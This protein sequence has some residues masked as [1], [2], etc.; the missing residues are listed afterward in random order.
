MAGLYSPKRSEQEWSDLA[1]LGPKAERI[2]D[3]SVVAST[4]KIIDDWANRR[5][6]RITNLGSLVDIENLTQRQITV[7][8]HWFL[9]VTR[10]AR[11]V[12]EPYKGQ[13]WEKC[14]PPDTLFDLP[15]HPPGEFVMHDEQD[16]EVI[17]LREVRTCSSCRGKGEVRCSKC[18]GKGTYRCPSCGG[19]GKKQRTEY[20]NG[21][22]RKYYEQCSRCRGSKKLDCTTCGKSGWVQC[23]TCEGYGKNLF[24]AIVSTSYKP[25]FVTDVLY[26]GEF[27]ANT[28]AD[29][30]I[31]GRKIISSKV[32]NLEYSLKGEVGP[33]EGD[34]NSNEEALKYVPYLKSI[35]QGFAHEV[36][37]DTKPYN[38]HVELRQIPV[39]EVPYQYGKKKY[40]LF[41]FGDD[42]RVHALSSPSAVA[43]F[44]GSA[45]KELKGLL[46]RKKGA[47]NPEEVILEACIWMCWADGELHEREHELIFE[48]LRAS[49][50]PKET[51]AKL[52]K[53]LK[54]KPKAFDLRGRLTEAD[55]SRKCAKFCWQV[56]ISDGE[57]DPAE[58]RAMA[59]LAEQ[60]GLSSEL[61]QI[62]RE[63]DAELLMPEIEIE[64]G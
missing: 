16:F 39:M 57:I 61:E 54:K 35:E 58:E 31:P 46:K 7:A 49:D 64:L 33:W 47:P 34:W 55:D 12:L 10:K 63:A 22:T 6:L 18:S 44:L 4:R 24:K 53:S 2:V 20:K 62:K 52:G 15:F 1:A 11:V 38:W 3:Q 51:K 60:L 14:D 25:D 41:L 32:F 37:E 40:K 23:S 45:F 50:L 56:T 59:D 36:T 17:G 30:D 26:R 27:P 42:N 21:K 29:P 43:A 19:A 9:H 13:E 48:F 28:L 5:L 8:S